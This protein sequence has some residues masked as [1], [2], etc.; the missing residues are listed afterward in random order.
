M[1]P[2]ASAGAPA[3]GVPARVA[4]GG[5]AVKGGVAAKGGAAAKG[6]GAAKAPAAPSDPRDPDGQL[7]AEFA[8]L[9]LS[10]KGMLTPD[11]VHAGLFAA[12]W[13]VDDVTRLFDV[14]DKDQDG[15]ISKE[16]FI[17]L[18]SKM[19]ASDGKDMDTQW[20]TFKLLCASKGVGINLTVHTTKELQK[21]DEDKDGA[22]DR[23]ELA[24]FVRF[25][26]EEEGVLSD[27]DF[28]IYVK[29]SLEQYDVD[30]D[31]KLSPPEFLAFYKSFILKVAA[32]RLKVEILKSRRPDKLTI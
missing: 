5:A 15:Q 25:V 24:K 10:Q 12:G 14:V 19:L 17:N 9:D 21:Y 22:L 6:G 30:S 16:E 4:K 20:Q 3:K 13:D 11:V 27:N 32:G 8:H 31:K 18:R 26:N 29:K 1:P 28:G 23:R 2:K 7:S